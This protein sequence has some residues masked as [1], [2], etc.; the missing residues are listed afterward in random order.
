MDN[1]KIMIPQN[2]YHFSV[3]DVF[4]S[5]I[6]VTDRQV[7]LFEHPFYAFLKKLHNQFGAD[8]SLYSFY[9]KNIDGKIHTLDEVRDLKEELALEPW[10]YFGPHA[11]DYNNPPYS[12]TPEKQIETFEKIYGQLERFVGR[13]HFSR[14]VRLQYYSE[15]YEL[16]GYF[17]S[18]GVQALFTT[19]KNA[20]SYR[21]PAEVASELLAKGYSSHLGMNFIRTNYRVEFFVD[22]SLSEP[23][24]TERFKST[25]EKYGF[26]V[27]YTH[28]IEMYKEQ[29]RNMAELMF[30]T[31][32]ALGLKSVVQA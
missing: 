15:S 16:A 20:G 3:D 29:G 28:E 19:D 9:Q 8:I 18:R 17:K 30:K 31:A 2:S 12:Q 25:V 10:L 4:D 24:V 14:F 22:E 7:G 5:L 1:Q 26:L 6:E 27:F 21:M 32:R 13:E 11:L 23:E